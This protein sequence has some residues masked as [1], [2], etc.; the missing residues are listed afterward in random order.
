MSHLQMSIL[1]VLIEEAGLT[2]GTEGRS[3]KKKLVEALMV[4]CAFLNSWNHH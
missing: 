3:T 1:E 2:L 4:H